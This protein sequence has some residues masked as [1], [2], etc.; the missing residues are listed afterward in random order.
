MNFEDDTQKVR[1]LLLDEALAKGIQQNEEQC[2]IWTT[3]KKGHQKVAETLQTFQKDLYVNCMVPIGKRALMKGKLIH[4]NEILACL[5][6]GYFAKYSASGA[7]ALCERRIQKAEE[8]LKNLNKERDLYET[9][10]MM[11][12]NNLF[13]DYAGGEIV[14]H[15]NEDQITEWKKKHRE[16][17]REYH[18]K[19]AKL[20]QEDRKKIETED[21]LFNRLDQLEIEEELADELNRLGDKAYELFGAEE[22]E[23]GQCYYESESSSNSEEEEKEDDSKEDNKQVPDSDTYEHKVKTC[24]VKKL[25]S[26][27]EPEDLSRKEK[28]NLMKEKEKDFEEDILRIEFTHSKNKSVTKSNGDSIET[29]ADIYR[30]LSKPKS[31][32]KRSPNDLPP[33]QSAPLEYSTEDEGEEDEDT[34]KPS[35]YETVVKDIKEKNTLEVTNGALEK[36]EKST[37]TRPVSKFKRERQRRQ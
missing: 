34:V 29:P 9:R 5:G 21:D 18:Q 19:L 10:M 20:R 24:K 7:A 13:E 36:M 30:L 3:Y 6:D 35:V 4:T 32:L 2:K 28:E 14:E 33:E 27:A 8:M 31:I 25:V 22:L 37:N 17:E 1:R 16:R 23:E 26:F 12:E 15:W 11:I